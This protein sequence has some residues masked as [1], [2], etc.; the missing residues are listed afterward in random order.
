MRPSWWPWWAGAAVTLPRRTPRRTSSATPW[1]T[2]CPERVLQFQ[3]T[4]WLMGKSWDHFAPIRPYVVTADGGGRAGNLDIACRVNGG[5]APAGQSPGI[6][7]SRP[8]PFWPMCPV[9]SPLEPG[10]IHCSP[11]RRAASCRASARGAHWLRPGDVVE[12]DIPGASAPCKARFVTKET[13][14]PS[15]RQSAWRISRYVRK[16]YRAVSQ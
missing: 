13:K 8:P 3:S 15:R 6:C 12:A 14:T 2:T 9:T 1:A 4:Q 5:G 11:A 16:A 7:S 10:D